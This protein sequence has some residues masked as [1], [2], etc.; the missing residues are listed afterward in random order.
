M[1]F[2][3]K[4]PNVSTAEL[5]QIILRGM[6]EFEFECSFLG[7]IKKISSNEN[8]QLRQ[9]IGAKFVPFSSK[10]IS[11]ATIFISH[12]WAYE[13]KD[14]V[15]CILFHFKFLMLLDPIQFEEVFVWIDI[16]SWNRRIL[17]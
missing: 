13:F 8:S 5:C 4:F 3:E 16:F 1:E 9:A 6:K 7:F 17:V 15:D 14:L 12:A 11:P 2:L 10:D